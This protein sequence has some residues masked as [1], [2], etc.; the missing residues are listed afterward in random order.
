[1][2]LTKGTDVEFASVDAP[3]RVA[4]KIDL[5]RVVNKAAPKRG[6]APVGEL[7]LTMVINRCLDPQAKTNIP[8]WYWR[9]YL[10]ELL[11]TDLPLASGS[12]THF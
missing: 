2:R 7:V 8:N 3:H 11:G 4:K 12:K 5:V 1:M 6:P 9:T 10:P